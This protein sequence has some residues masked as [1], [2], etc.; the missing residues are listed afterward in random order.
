[1]EDYEKDRSWVV[2]GAQ[3]AELS[4]SAYGD[5]ARLTQIQRLT[6]TQIVLAG[7]RRY[8]RE[9]LRPVGEGYYRSQLVPANYPRVQNALAREVLRNLVREV[10][11]LGK[12]FKGGRDEVLA[13]I[14][15]VAELAAIARR[16]VVGE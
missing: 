1:M 7:G 5:Y 3:V 11:A 6:K 2:E 8:N 14:D 10:E 4:W 12:N 9:R 16:Q 15:R 13:Q